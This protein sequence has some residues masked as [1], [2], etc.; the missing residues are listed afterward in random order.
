MKY[1]VYRQ[2]LLINVAPLYREHDGESENDR[3]R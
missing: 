3:K 1:K 2:V